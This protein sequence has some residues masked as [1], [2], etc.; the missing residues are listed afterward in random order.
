MAS[1]FIGHI[2]QQSK[3]QFGGFDTSYLANQDASEGYGIEWFPL[4]GT[5]WWQI[6]LQDTQYGESSVSSGQTA[7]CIM[8]TGTSLIAVPDYEFN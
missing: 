2:N 6:K 4:I 1:F 7:T 3:V 5:T 8:D